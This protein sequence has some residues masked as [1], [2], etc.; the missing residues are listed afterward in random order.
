MALQDDDAGGEKVTL[1]FGTLPDGVSLAAPASMAVTITDDEAANGSPAFGEGAAATRT[2]AENAAAGTAVGAPLKAT[3]PD[4]DPLTYRLG[5]THAA[6]FT[7]GGSS[8]QLKVGAGAGFDFEGAVNSYAVTVEVSDGKDASGAADAAADDAI[9]VTVDVTDLAEP[10]GAPAAPTLTS[11]AKSLAAA[12]AAPDNA[13]PAITGYDLHYRSVGATDWTDAQLSGTAT[14]ATVGGLAAG[15]AYEVRVRAAS[16]E[17]AGGWS[18]VAVANTLPAV[19]LS[20][21][22]LS[23]DIPKGDAAATVTLS[24]LPGAAGGGTLKGA[25]L[26]RDGEGTV[27]VLDGGLPLTDGT[28]VRRAVSSAAPGPRTFGFR[29]THTLAGRT[30]ESTGWVTVNWR[31]QV[32]LSA[33]PSNVAEDG[34]AAGV[35]VTATLT[36]TALTDAAK[37]VGV[38]VTGGT[39]AEGDDF[40]AVDDF[41][42]RIAGGA[43]S[44]VGSFTLTPVAD[45]SREGSETVEVAG[46]ASDGRPLTVLGTAVRIVDAEPELTVAT[47]VNGTVTGTT[48][49]GDGRRTVIDCGGGQRTTCSATLAA[50]TRIALSATAGSG[51]RF[52][53]WGG[54][55]ASAPSADCSV[56]LTA[57]RAVSV[58]FASKSVDGECDE[59]AV[60]ACAA[61]A[62]NAAAASDTDSHHR[63]RCDGSGGGANSRICARAKAGCSAGGRDWTV[64]ANACAGPVTDAASGQARAASDGVGPATGSASFKCDDGA[65][66]EQPGSVCGRECAGGTRAHCELAT[67]AHGGS[68]GACG[69]NS[70]GSCSYSCSDG[71]WTRRSGQCNARC[72][73]GSETWRVGD[74]SCADTLGGG[75]HGA[76]RTASD[77]AG[78][79]R[80]SASFKCDD[81]A[82]LEQSGSTCER[83]CRATTHS[84]RVGS[85]QCSARL[86][87]LPSQWSDLAE[88]DT[89]PDTGTARYACDDGA[90]QDPT[91]ARCR[92]GCAAATVDDCVLGN[93]VHGDS[94]GSC[95]KGSGSCSYRCDDGAWERQGNSCRAD[96]DAGTETWTVGGNS[97]TGTLDWTRHGADRTATDGTHT[98][99]DLATGS[100]TYR[101]DDGAFDGP[102]NASCHAVCGAQAVAGC[103]LPATAH[104]GRTG[105]CLG[106][107][108]SCSYQC[109]DGVWAERSNSCPL[110][111]GEATAKWTVDGDACEATL[112][113]T[114]H[115]A[116]RTVKDSTHSATG[117]ATYAC[118]YG[119][120]N[121]PTN[122]S[123]KAGC[124]GDTLKRCKLS[125]G[126]HGD[127]SG[128]CLSGDTGSC[129]YTC[130]DGTWD[131]GGNSCAAPTFTVRVHPVPTK[132]KVT[133]SGFTCPGSVCKREFQ[134]QAS[135]NGL[136]ATPNAGYSFDGWGLEGK[137][138]CGTSSPCSFKVTQDV[139]FN[140]QFSTPL[141]AKAGGPYTT[142]YVPPI[143]PPFGYT[144]GF[145]FAAVK[146][147]ASG[148]VPPYEF[149]WSGKETG[150]TAFYSY[151]ARSQLP[152]TATVTVTDADGEKEKATADI[153]LPSANAATDGSSEPHRFEVP[154]GGG[155]FFIWGGDK[156]VTARATG[157]AVVEV[158]VSSPAFRVTGIGLGETVVVVTTADGEWS[159][160]VVV[161]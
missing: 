18:A 27:T 79:A 120:Y 110:N 152:A 52:S 122:A 51:H 126:V 131:E 154:L 64:G 22:T 132:G 2:V 151:T 94:A 85:A 21:P 145:Y 112:A 36:G 86:D 14:A 75:V 146:A 93:G 134:G 45:A 24:A 107:T 115:G 55:C 69:A 117:S 144:T 1:G 5:G 96:C 65:W 56:V 83:E 103:D 9:S 13:G 127:T 50:G 53:R 80:G 60:D 28:A 137:K 59:T 106:S 129:S 66:S 30:G 118:S 123:C 47:S 101:C 141:E 44:A 20:A 116:M 105:S 73:T 133:G 160:P 26:E 67:T 91:S 161:R 104:G 157:A 3:D 31:P 8:G 49:S 77:N 111:C 46:A 153:E 25:W 81:G 142:T 149:Q 113:P 15:A 128:A 109:N 89:Y 48:G 6:L 33:S 150:A 43:R 147:T 102:T 7:V 136:T 98:A 119:S 125:K 61:G 16:D 159:V 38:S 62:P 68:S 135:I 87:A 41:T 23:P 158:S 10:P 84:W 82:W 78:S 138:V 90:W 40:K 63:W 148:G 124:A 99:T 32:V 95:A 74:D 121:G 114:D 156:A 139:T 57:D 37:T 39:A 155:I 72:P 54:A 4:G 11:T 76:T 97:C 100:A 92:R 88:D 35:T 70:T 58:A 42:V 19:S 71:A 130:D 140:P 34:G 143:P 12:W 108:G 17:G 29:A